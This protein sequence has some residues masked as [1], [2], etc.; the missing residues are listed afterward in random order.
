MDQDIYSEHILEH[1]RQPRN[2]KVME[3]CSVSATLQNEGCADEL[4]AYLRIKNNIVEEITFSGVG[5]AI[6]TAAA[7][8]F[9]TYI[10]GKTV[11]AV[12]AIVPGEV[13]TLLGVTIHPMR[14][15]CALLMYEAVQKAIVQY[16]RN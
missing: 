16:V 1:A 5:C 15:R 12:Q 11:I 14:S 6:S 10:Q 9:S 3:P 8:L 7:S 13:Y 4:V 2:K